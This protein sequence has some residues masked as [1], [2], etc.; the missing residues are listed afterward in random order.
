MN[1]GKFLNY[2]SK[3]K[4]ISKFS[5]I[6]LA[7]YPKN[8]SNQTCNYWFTKP[9]QQQLQNNTVNAAILIT[10]NHVIVV[11][12]DVILITGA[13]LMITYGHNTDTLTLG[14]LIRVPPAYFF[15]INFDH[16]NLT[17]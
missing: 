2:P 14:L 9:N 11:V 7:I 6:T 3:T 16:L 13:L 15:Q 12:I 10:I 5:K 17:I 4:A 8:C 1:F